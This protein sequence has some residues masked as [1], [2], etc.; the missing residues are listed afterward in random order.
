MA[1]VRDSNVAGASRGTTSPVTWNHTVAA[2]GVLYVSIASLFP[3]AD[4]I[5]AVTFDGAA[6]TLIKKDT[7]NQRQVQVW[8]ILN[9]TTGSAKAVSISFTGSDSLYGGSV[10]YTGVDT[11][12]FSA[13]TPVEAHNAGVTTSIS[14]SITPTVDNSVILGTGYAE[15]G[16]PS[17][18][19]NIVNVG[20]ATNLLFPIES[21]P[22]LISPA[23]ATTIGITRPSNDWIKLVAFVAEPATGSAVKAPS[24]SLAL[25]GCGM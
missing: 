16:A 4:P 11:T 8:G 3:V 7:N 2:G 19:T 24:G 15:N 23:A 5:T 6:M 1:I 21:S 12:G 14:T 22:L 10:S 18:Y 25:M 13:V 20:V 17:A 9:P